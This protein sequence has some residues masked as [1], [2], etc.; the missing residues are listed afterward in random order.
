MVTYIMSRDYFN[1]RCFIEYKKEWP[2]DRFLGNTILCLKRFT[3]TSL[4]LTIC[5][6]SIRYE[7]NH[8]RAFLEMLYQ[9]FNRLMTPLWSSVSKAAERSNRTKTVVL[10]SS[11]FLNKLFC[12]FSNAVSVECMGL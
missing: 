6:R 7:A 8:R 5:C 1:K 11:K 9:F 3:H 4:I 2:E 12:T 10:P